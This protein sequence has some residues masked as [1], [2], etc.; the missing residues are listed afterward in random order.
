[1]RAL[2]LIGL[3]LFYAIAGFWRPWL[4][5]RR[6]G[7]SANFMFRSGGWATRLRDAGAVVV[8]TLLLG[9]A[10]VAAG[11]PARLSP[12][13]A[14]PSRAGMLLAA[15][16]AVL[17]FAGLILLVTAQLHLGASWRIGI[18]A[19]ARPGLVTDRLYAFS[20]NP[21]FLGML[22]LVA[23]YAMMLPTV[24]SL[25]VLVALYL[26]IRQQVAAEEAYLVATY[27]EAYR[28]YAARVG[29]FVPGIG[30]RRWLP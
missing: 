5:R 22:V 13:V 14:P 30:K 9:Q 10:I 23:G 4:Q 21:I 18:E 20:R 17:L 29:R 19:G 28:A 12:L 7:T 24:L 3:V 26:G 25:V 8:F 27:G 11:W 16:G 2:P 1:M 6:Y 15:A